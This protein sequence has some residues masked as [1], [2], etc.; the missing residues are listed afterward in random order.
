MNISILPSL[1]APIPE[2]QATDLMAYDVYSLMAGDLQKRD[3]KDHVPCAAPILFEHGPYIGRTAERMLKHGETHGVQRSA[4]HAQNCEAQHIMFD[5]DELSAEQR[6]VVLR[7]LD[8]HQSFAYSSYSHGR[9]DKVGTSMRLVIFLDK[10]VHGIQG[11]QT[12]WRGI[13]QTFFPGL[14]DTSSSRPYQMQGVWATAPDRVE[15]AWCETNLRDGKPLSSQEFSRIGQEAIERSPFGRAGI[16]GKAA[17]TPMPA[18]GLDPALALPPMLETEEQNEIF[19]A[20][21]ML[22]SASTELMIRVFGCLKALGDEYQGHLE[23]WVASNPEA[24]EKYRRKHPTKYDPRHMWQ[25][26]HPTIKREVGIATI[27]C[28]ARSSAWALF[29]ENSCLASAKV[30]VTYLD[31]YHPAWLMQQIN[32]QML[33]RAA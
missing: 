23:T 18:A 16:I 32:E 14:A 20:L 26:W 21:C 24:V 8:Q 4:S 2:Y 9:P 10:P 27:K 29:E 11:Y 6:D 22:D 17:L 1:K 3:S 7:V 5:F 25:G 28:L 31:R 12:V 30:S 33:G 13:E 19:D 15:H